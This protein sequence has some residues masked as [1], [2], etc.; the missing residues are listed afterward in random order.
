[1]LFTMKIDAYCFSSR[2]WKKVRK[3][4]SN[5]IIKYKPFQ[6]E[7]SHIHRTDIKKGRDSYPSLCYHLSSSIAKRLM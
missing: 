2:R 3:M 1:M 7:A 5:N 6:Q 4:F